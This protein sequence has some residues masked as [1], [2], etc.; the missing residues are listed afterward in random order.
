VDIKRKWNFNSLRHMEVRFLPNTYILCMKRE[1]GEEFS[2][3]Q[4]YSRA[5]YRPRRAKEK[6][7]IKHFYNE[8]SARRVI[9]FSFFIFLNLFKFSFLFI[10]LTQ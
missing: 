8:E 2:L 9:L 6:I 5:I 3:F 1:V 10:S 7:I 4:L